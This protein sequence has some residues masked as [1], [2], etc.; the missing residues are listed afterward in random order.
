LTGYTPADFASG[1][2][3]FGSLVLPQDYQR[4]QTTFRAAIDQ[5]KSYSVDFRIKDKDSQ[6]KWLRGSGQPVY[7]FQ[8]TFKYLDGFYVDITDQKGV[9]AQLAGKVKELEKLNVLLVGRE[10]KMIEL[11]QLLNTIQ[12]KD[13]TTTG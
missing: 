1:R 2:I 9:E 6:L 11:K 5:R 7:D 8:G 12:A 10:K 3:K 13:G 4:I